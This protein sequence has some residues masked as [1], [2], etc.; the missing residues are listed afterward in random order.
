[1]AAS[2]RPPRQEEEL[3][4]EPSRSTSCSSSPTCSVS[5]ALLLVSAVS[6]YFRI[7]MIIKSVQEDTEIRVGPGGEEFVAGSAAAVLIIDS[8]GRLGHMTYHGQRSTGIWETPRAEDVG[9]KADFARR[10]CGMRSRDSEDDM[11]VGASTARRPLGVLHKPTADLRA[12]PRYVRAH[13]C[14]PLQSI[15][16]SSLHCLSWLLAPFL[17]PRRARYFSCSS[18]SQWY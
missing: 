15:V 10:P 3:H 9:P 6:Y 7:P 17:G 5:A 13:T 16:S 4:S 11:E 14:S 8:K 2:R 18:F 12:D 1:M